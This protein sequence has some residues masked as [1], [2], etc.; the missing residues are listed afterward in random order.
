M[1][2]AIRRDLK[3]ACE[4]KRIRLTHGVSGIHWP[5]GRDIGQPR[6]A[7]RPLVVG[8][9]TIRTYRQKLIVMRRGGDDRFKKYEK[10]CD[11]PTILR[12]SDCRIYGGKALEAEMDARLLNTT[13]LQ[14]TVL[15]PAPDGAQGRKKGRKKRLRKCTWHIEMRNLF[16]MYSALI[17][18]Q[19]LRGKINLFADMFMISNARTQA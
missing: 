13:C 18:S 2:I 3:K 7:G 11:T 8:L 10:W 12:Q 4:D 16:T 14:L 9:T 19:R 1:A 15:M 5:F 17:S 6:T